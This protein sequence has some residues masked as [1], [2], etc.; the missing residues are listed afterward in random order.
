MSAAAGPSYERSAMGSIYNHQRVGERAVSG[1]SGPR[2]CCA[3]EWDAIFRRYGPR[4][5]RLCMHWTR[6]HRA[7]AQDLLAEAYLRAVCAS[8][9][10]VAL[11]HNPMAWLSTVVANLARDQRRAAARNRHDPGLLEAIADSRC[12]SDALLMKRQ[13]LSLT[14]AHARALT[15]SQRAALLA[16][17]AG[18]GYEAIAEQLGTSKGNARKLVQTARNTLRGR[19]ALAKVSLR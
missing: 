4:V 8:E 6:G 5:T 14:L 15:P 7:D 18:E 19:L 1:I 13:L 16:R 17:T 12:A 2:C 11:P 9:Q 3:G 10:S